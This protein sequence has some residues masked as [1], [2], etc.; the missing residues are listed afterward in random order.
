[1]EFLKALVEQDFGY[2]REDTDK[3]QYRQ[4]QAIQIRENL[5]LS[6]QASCAH[7]SVPRETLSD[8]S[9]Y[10]R[11]ELALIRT[12]EDASDSEFVRVAD[13]L[14]NFSSL[15]EIELHEQTVYAYVPADLVE[16]LYLALIDLK[17]RGILH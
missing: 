2:V 14:P 12:E 17:E 15:A 10:K 11:W 6:I 13:I 4:F 7:Y 16:E 9:K 1:M 3:I 8:L 5:W